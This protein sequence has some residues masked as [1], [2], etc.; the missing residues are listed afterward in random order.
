MAAAAIGNMISDVAG[1]GLAHYV[2]AAVARFGIRHPSLNAQ[3]V[4]SFDFLT[5]L[6]QFFESPTC[7]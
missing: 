7:C 3:Q 4:T 6:V 5:F 1:I 2:E